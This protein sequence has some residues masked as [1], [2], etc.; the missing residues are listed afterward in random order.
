MNLLFVVFTGT[1]NGVKSGSKKLMC[2]YKGLI[3]TFKEKQI[4]INDDT[5]HI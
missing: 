1:N 5:Y 2:R 4:S 3:Q